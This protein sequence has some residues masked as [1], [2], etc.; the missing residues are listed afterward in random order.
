ME[1]AQGGRRVI[2]FA[3]ILF[4]DLAVKIYQVTHLIFKLLLLAFDLFNY[5]SFLGLVK[6]VITLIITIFILFKV[7]DSCQTI[8]LVVATT[9]INARCPLISR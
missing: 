1:L 6:H 2:T 3:D 7:S 4:T 5:A 9:S 8:D